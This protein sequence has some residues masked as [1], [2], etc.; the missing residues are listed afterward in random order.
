MLLYV[1]S[2]ES[3]FVNIRLLTN[4]SRSF[5]SFERSECKEAAGACRPA[6]DASMDVL[7]KDFCL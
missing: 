3:I 5:I 6:V 7:Q 1:N 4:F 2:E